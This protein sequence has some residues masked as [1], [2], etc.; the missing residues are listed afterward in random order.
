MKWVCMFFFIDVLG[1][2]EGCHWILF[3]SN[4]VVI[5]KFLVV[6]LCCAV[7]PYNDMGV[8]GWHWLLHG[9]VCLSCQGNLS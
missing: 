5:Y 8:V 7:L 1:L 2:G 4:S 9:I 6:L 3:G